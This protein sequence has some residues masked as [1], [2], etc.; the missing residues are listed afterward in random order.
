MISVDRWSQMNQ[1]TVVTRETSGLPIQRGLKISFTV[2]P[3]S[4][5]TYISFTKMFSTQNIIWW[6]NEDTLY[7]LRDV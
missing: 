6:N 3:T 4:T 7:F 5:Y 2:F 1:F